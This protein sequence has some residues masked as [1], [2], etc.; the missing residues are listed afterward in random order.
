MVMKMQ[1]LMM[2]IHKKVVMKILNQQDIQ[3]LKIK[4]IHLVIEKMGLK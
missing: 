1:T 4:I 3:R 2:E